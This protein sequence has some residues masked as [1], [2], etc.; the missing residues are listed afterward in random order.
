MIYCQLTLLLT[1]LSIVV[2][3]FVVHVR[4]SS[5]GMSPCV[6]EDV[7]MIVSKQGSKERWRT[8]LFQVSL[9]DKG[10]HSD[11]LLLLH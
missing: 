3:T 7:H 9:L 10:S 1:L 2:Q 8:K 6:R 5:R 4:K 11:F